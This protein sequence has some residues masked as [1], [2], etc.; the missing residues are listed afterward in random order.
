MRGTPAPEVP[1]V[2]V[3]GNDEITVRERAAHI[4]ATWNGGQQLG[5]EILDGSATTAAEA[6][7]V[8]D[9]V[10]EALHTLP[11]PGSTKIVWLRNCAFL[12]TDR[13]GDAPAVNEALQAWARELERFDWRGVRLLI[14]AGK[15]DRRR[16][17]IKLLE[18]IGRVEIHE[19]WSPEDRDWPDRAALWVRNRLRD[20]GFDI[21]EEALVAFLS[22]VGPHLGLLHTELEKLCLY[23]APRTRIGLDDVATMTTRNRT[24][25]AFALADAVGA[26]DLSRALQCLEDER[27]S[28]QGEADRSGLGLLYGLAF[29]VRAMLWARE[30]ADQGWVHPRIDYPSFK[31]R[32]QRIP[33]DRLPAERRISPLSIHPF[34]LH[35][36]LRDAQNYSRTE[37]VQAMKRLLEC[38]RALVGSRHDPA[39]LLQQLLVQIVGETRRPQTGQ[40]VTDPS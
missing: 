35:K 7:T 12:G 9:R 21:D 30:M 14:S 5:D 16:A 1:V 19:A 36:A 31:A 37:L 38:N 17:L 11:L 32:L 26:R 40:T 28:S 22:Q 18:Q 25:R 2:L 20:A 23:I 29:K 6:L 10:R 13:P 8:L 34:V 15:V 33:T 24:A 3:C 4:F 39:L 27:R